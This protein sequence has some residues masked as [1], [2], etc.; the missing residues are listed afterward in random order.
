MD[1]GT[2]AYCFDC[3]RWYFDMLCHHLMD[4]IEPLTN[5]PQA[6]LPVVKKD[7][8]HYLMCM[9]IEKEQCTV[10]TKTTLEMSVH[11]QRHMSRKGIID[12]CDELINEWMMKHVV[13]LS[14]DYVQRTGDQ[15]LGSSGNQTLRAMIPMPLRSEYR[16][17]EPSANDD[18]C[19]RRRVT[20]FVCKACKHVFTTRKGMRDH[21]SLA[22][23]DINIIRN[24]L[25]DHYEPN[26]NTTYKRNP[27]VAKNRPASSQTLIDDFSASATSV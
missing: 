5:V 23:P 27:W 8:H 26:I 24:R 18:I 19:V 22:H 2:P 9:Y 20:G 16:R 17:Y 12:P 14:Q 7:R 4:I 15:Y 1:D 3:E 25:S 10:R 21:M 13:I 11:V 6:V